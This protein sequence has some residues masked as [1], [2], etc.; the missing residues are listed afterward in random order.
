M[1]VGVV[2]SHTKNN[3]GPQKL[4]EA[5]RVLP[6]SLRRDCGLADTLISNSGL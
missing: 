3:W 5:G 4:E 1:E 2:L 6:Y